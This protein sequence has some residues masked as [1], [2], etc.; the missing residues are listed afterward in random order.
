LPFSPENGADL[1]PLLQDPGFILHPPLL[2]LGYVG[3]A[4]PFAFALTALLLG[5]IQNN[6]ARWARPWALLAWGFL[7]LGIALGSWWAYYELGWGGWWFW[8]PVENASFMPWLM[9]AA[10]THALYVCVKRGIFASWS[11]L[12]AICVFVLSLM[13]TFLVRSGV[14]SSVH[15]FASSPQ[16]GIY[17]L[18]FLLVIILTSLAVYL[19]QIQ[20]WP[21]SDK[22]ALFTKESFILLGNVI[23]IVGTLTVLLGT[24][25]PLGVEVFT[26]EKISVGPPYFNAVFIPIMFPLLL[27][28]GFAPYFTWGA[29][30]TRWLYRKIKTFWPIGLCIILAASYV[31]SHAFSVLAILGVL[32]GLWILLSTLLNFFSYF[33]I[34]N[35]RLTF[36]L[37][38]QKWGMVFAHAGIA[39]SVLGMSLLT[40]LETERELKMSPGEIINVGG[41]DF[42]FQDIE[43]T[44]G[45]NYEGKKAAFIVKSQ[46]KTIAQVFPEKRFFMPREL[47]ISETAIHA[48]FL[49]DFYVALGEK[50]EIESWSVRL[51][52]KPFIRW[53]WLGGLMI[54][55]GAGISGIAALNVNEDYMLHRS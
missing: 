28:M 35:N 49:R 29:L 12:L 7:T 4:L 48:G 45:P 31:I 42:L 38:W 51:Y 41:Y 11:L 18:G 54:A 39:V 8:D 21:H 52:I 47:A 23:L 10:L 6:W 2:Y 44:K 13:G 14:L 53:I 27:L 40:T 50:L 9:G 1:N 15:A 33:K 5:D 19:T 24:L 25:Y 20:K 30:Q 26:H 17:I 55:L 16:R 32:L 36:S 37:P 46:D 34:K 3:F 22:K 43:D